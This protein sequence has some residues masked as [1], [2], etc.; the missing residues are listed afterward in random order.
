M[1]DDG[2]RSAVYLTVTRFSDLLEK[3]VPLFDK[4]PIEGTKRLDFIEF[5]NVAKIVNDKSHLT[6]EGIKQICEIKTRMNTGRS[7]FL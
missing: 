5:K 7:N 3:I 1:S 2:R 4:Y 6:S